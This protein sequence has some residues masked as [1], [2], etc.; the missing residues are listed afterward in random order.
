MPKKNFL[1]F[2]LKNTDLKNFLIFSQKKDFLIF[3][4]TGLSYIFSEKKLFL[5]FGKWNFLTLRIKK[6][7]RELSELK[8]LKE[9]QKNT[10]K[11]FLIFGKWNFLAPRL[12]NFLYFRRELFEHEK[13]RLLIFLSEKFFPHFWTTADQAIKEKSLLCSGINADNFVG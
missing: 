8:K 12:E 5:H 13:Q 6:F 1:Y 9:K 11:K 4:E 7:R 2:F 3:R 10:L